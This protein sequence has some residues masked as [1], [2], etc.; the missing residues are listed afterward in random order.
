MATSNPF[1][2]NRFCL[3]C[4]GFWVAALWLLPRLAAAEG[5][6]DR[7]ADALVREFRDHLHEFVER[8]ANRFAAVYTNS[9]R[10]PAVFLLQAQSRLALHRYDD[11]IALLAAHQAGAGKLADE[12]AFWQ[13]QARF[14]KGD[15]S[16]AAESFARMAAD[17]PDSARRLEAAVQEALA[18]YRAGDPVQASARLRDPNG[19]FQVASKAAPDSEWTQR[20]RLLLAQLQ[21]GLNDIPGGQQVLAQMAGPQLPPGIE[22]QRQLLLARA[23]LVAGRLPEALAHT[24]NLW[25]S[26]TNTLPS[27]LL[28]EAADLQGRIYEGLKQPEA[29][30]DAFERNL[31]TNAPPTQR[32]LALEKVVE[33]SRNPGPPGR[34]LQRLQAFV[35]QNPQDELIDFARFALGEALLREYYRLADPATPVTPENSQ[36]K[37]NALAQARSQFEQLLTSQPQSPFAPRAELD[38]GWTLWEEGA[39]RLADA[40]A[41]FRSATGHLPPSADQSTARLKWADCQVRSGDLQGA[42]TNYWTLATNTVEAVVPKALR[43]QALFQ[44]VRT[45]I[46]AGDLSAANRASQSLAQVDAGGELA[47]RADLLVARA[48]SRAGQPGPARAQYEAF[49]QRYTN[50]PF[51]PEVRLAIGRTFEDRGD[52]GA[53]LAA[54]TSWLAN[55]TNQTGI[56]TGLVAQ[57]T[58][59]LARVSYRSSPDAAAVGLLTNFIAHFPR[60]T[61]APLAQYLVGEYLLG[62][63]DYAKAELAFRDKLLDPARS[64]PGDELPYRARLM[65]GKAAV[66]LQTWQNAREHFDWI[67][68][69]GPLHMVSSPIPVSVVA[70]AYIFRGDLF[71]M[72]PKAQGAN[73][74]AGYA[75]AITAFAKVAEQFPT[76]ELAPIAWGRIGDC[77]LQLA[78][79]DPKRYDA[80]AEAYKKVIESNA[81]PQVRS[82]AEV[83]LAIVLEKQ[84][85][86]RPAAEQAPIL[87]AAM[88]HYRSVFYGTNLRKGE[89]PDPIWVRQA[90]MSAAQLAQSRQQWETAISLYRRLGEELPAIR[91]RFEKK[92]EE[93]QKLRQAGTAPPDG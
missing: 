72:E 83:G 88:D 9:T 16:A 30:L 45:G 4:C 90:G 68:T 43:N 14:E 76:N 3:I 15:W 82:M 77:N 84:A 74:L 93:L 6:E 35:T 10:L 39:P 49:L 47:Q 40:L 41:A 36:A 86:L 28:A 13:A 46:E 58:F 19:P 22:W 11:A 31:T 32:R 89:Q 51:I 57:A 33:M 44:V 27:T 56:Q 17:F 34:A 48:L 24:T 87:D 85:M 69:N 78:S 70:E 54:Y 8:D 71:T 79:Q 66:F 81:G 21:I 52:N 23:A 50:S 67:I 55:Y 80:A 59:D 65:A 62:Q 63:G 61:N 75:E 7:A 26:V 29:A 18:R 20:G 2:R 37:T 60:S 38:R 42:L 1:M 91:A 64:P 92:I 25:T 73:P 5:E 12:F 53:A